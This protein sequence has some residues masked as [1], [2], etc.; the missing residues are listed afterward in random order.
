MKKKTKN[1]GPKLKEPK[2]EPPCDQNKTEDKSDWIEEEVLPFDENEFVVNEDQNI[3][4]DKTNDDG[5]SKHSFSTLDSSYPMSQFDK[6]KSEETD[7]IIELL[8]REGRVIFSCKICK[9]T[10]Q[11]KTKA[12]IHAETH[13]NQSKLI[14]LE[15]GLESK[16]SSSLYV[17]MRRKH[18][19]V[20][21]SENEK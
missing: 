14:C 11:R 17:H 18:T 15:C 7:K 21:A 13:L 6:S 10:N 5:D 20:D 3:E 12:R 16:T 1:H 2:S 19:A 8:G 4:D 9:K